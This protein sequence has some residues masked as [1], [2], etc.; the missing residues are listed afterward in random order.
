MDRTVYEMLQDIIEWIGIN[1]SL[2]ILGGL[3]V[4]YYVCVEGLSIADNN[5]EVAIR[6]VWSRLQLESKEE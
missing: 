3:E 1:G 2:R 4:N 6:Q 5:L